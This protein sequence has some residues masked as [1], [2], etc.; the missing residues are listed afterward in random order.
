M[1]STTRTL[2]TWLEFYADLM[3]KSNPGLATR[4][5]EASYEDLTKVT[6]GHLDKPDKFITTMATCSPFGA[7]V[8]HG[9]EGNVT[10]LHHGT[11]YSRGLGMDPVVVFVSGNRISSPF[12]TLDIAETVLPSDPGTLGQSRLLVCIA[13]HKLGL[14]DKA[15]TK[16]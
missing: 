12:K 3:N 11:L 4:W 13:M 8:V 6:K 15:R 7:I 9:T 1:A 14:P 16:D 2:S 5:A 10:I